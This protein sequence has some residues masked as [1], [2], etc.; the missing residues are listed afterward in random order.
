MSASAAPLIWD[1]YREI[2]NDTDAK[3]GGV[4]HYYDEQA[5]DLFLNEGMKTRL[6]NPVGGSW[7]SATLKE[8]QFINTTNYGGLSIDHPAN[9]A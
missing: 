2:G 3:L 8:S 6:T 1:F 9:I 5:Q 7:E 4:V